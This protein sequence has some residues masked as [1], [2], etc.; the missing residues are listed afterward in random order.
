MLRSE[1]NP[2]YSQPYELTR[3]VL[4][5]ILDLADM[6]VP[7]PHRE[8]CRVLNQLRSRSTVSTALNDWS[9]RPGIDCLEVA[10][11]SD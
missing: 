2:F 6:M 8:S 1:Q 9:Q 10:R 5:F 7:D 3:D 4:R 11:P